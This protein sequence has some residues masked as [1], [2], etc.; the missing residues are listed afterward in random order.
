[1][2]LPESVQTW[3][4]KLKPRQRHWVM[5]AGIIVVTVGTL[6]ALFTATES[7]TKLAPNAKA[8]EASKVTNVGV[9]PGGAQVKPLD[10]WIGDAGRKMAQYE[11]DKEN[12]QKRDKDQQAFQEQVS[13]LSLIHI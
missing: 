4:G 7:P 8:P 5:L 11:K 12:Q 3:F 13:K 6:W 9:M 10:Q 1:M 2:R